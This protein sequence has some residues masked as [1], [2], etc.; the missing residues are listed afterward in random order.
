[1]LELWLLGCCAGHLPWRIFFSSK[2]VLLCNE[3]TKIIFTDE[4]TKITP[5]SLVRTS[6][7][8]YRATVFVCK[9]R[10]RGKKTFFGCHSTPQH[11]GQ[12]NLARTGLGM[13]SA[14]CLSN[15]PPHGECADSA[16]KIGFSV[17]FAAEWAK[18]TR[19]GETD[20]Q[21]EVPSDAALGWPRYPHAVFSRHDGRRSKTVPTWRSDCDPWTNAS[22]S[23]WKWWATPWWHAWNGRCKVQ[24]RIIRVRVVWPVPASTLKGHHLYLRRP[25]LD[26]PRVPLLPLHVYT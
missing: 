10:T 5:R 1:M 9:A 14:C 12:P 2:I 20:V 25:L 24:G 3:I 17:F 13:N 6:T 19:Q 26:P 15:S 7:A 18:K 16:K 4:L 11:G 23:G 21:L 22:S 8:C